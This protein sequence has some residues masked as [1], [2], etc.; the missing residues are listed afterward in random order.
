VK[1]VVIEDHQLVRDMLVES[2]GH[3]LPGAEARGASTGAEGVRVCCEF[4]P[5]LVFLDLALPDGDGLDFIADIFAASPGAK[6]VALT[7]H[8]DEF[9]LYRALRAQVHGFVDKNEQPL[10]VLGEVIA[11]VMDG[12]RYFSPSAQRL[13]LAMRNNPVDFSKLLS[14]REQE[15]LAWFGA[16]LTDEEIGGRLDLAARTVKKHRLRIM[17]KLGVH[18]TPQ[19]MRYALEKGFTRVQGAPHPVARASGS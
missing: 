3:V 14:D 15:L 12:G 7:S 9:T 1:I 6:V 11:S 4:G 13:R 18:S 19:L 5:G 10:K 17:G 2:C 16:G 8:T